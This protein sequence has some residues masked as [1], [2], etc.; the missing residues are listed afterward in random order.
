[1]SRWRLAFAFG[2]TAWLTLQVGSAHA[3]ASSCVKVLL[4]YVGKPLAKAFAEKGAG[5]AAEYFV[6]KVKQSQHV[7][8]SDSSAN[9]LTQRDL[10]ELREIYAQN[11]ESECQLRQD[12]QQAMVPAYNPDYMVPVVPRV[13][14]CVTLS[15]ACQVQV[16]TGSNFYC[17]NA[18]GQVF[19]GIAQ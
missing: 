3:Q 9:Q 11:G 12:L 5:L 1:M 4:E 19:P 10:E 13:S 15:G 2:V 18:W 17:Y 16:S 8:R 7:G 6:A 14:L